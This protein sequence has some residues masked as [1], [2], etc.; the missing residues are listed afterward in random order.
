MVPMLALNLKADLPL[1]LPLGLPIKPYFD[2]GYFDDATSLGKDRPSNE[3]LL[4]SGGL[5]FQFFNSGLEVYF[6]CSVPKP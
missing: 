3:Q 6:P 4:W 5:M 2:L 1:R